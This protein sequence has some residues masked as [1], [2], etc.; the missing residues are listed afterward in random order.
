MMIAIS[1]AIGDPGN[2]DTWSGAPANLSKAL[3]QLGAD[4]GFIDS[5]C[6]FGYATKLV[7]AAAGY[8]AGKPLR[9]VSW[10]EP[11]R[12]RRGAFVEYRARAL[13]ADHVLCMGSL[14]APQYSSRPY[15]I[16]M[17]NTWDLLWNSPARPAG[18]TDRDYAEI[19]A[20]EREVLGC[21][22]HVFAFSHHVRA[23]L[24]RHYRIPEE[25]AL[26]VGCGSGPIRPF[27]G[28]KDYA[29]G[30]LLFVAKHLFA[31]KGGNLVL[32]A[33]ETIRRCRKQTKL[34]II[35]NDVLRDR[36]RGRTNV[37]VHGYL[38]WEELQSLYN[39][40]SMLVQPMLSDPWG[41]VYLEAMKT[42]TIVVS[43]NVAAVPEI[44]DGGRLGIMVDEP[45]PPALAEAVLEAFD[46]PQRLTD[47]AR[48]A[49][50]RVEERYTWR[51]V[52]Q[53]IYMRLNDG[54]A[55]SRALG[56]TADAGDL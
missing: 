43:L 25:R 8:L 37:T 29:K 20:A 46:H 39:G 40:S 12:R 33:F 51:A 48:E 14:D 10:R 13:Q 24:I 18:F 35:G 34:V 47:I 55:T 1:S 22:R 7:L 53:R 17:D 5:S 26:A 52:A 38:P 31:E 21:A 23:N 27:R 32:E 49:Q 2:P 6:A 11:A 4:M 16:Y 42:R 56:G 15:S 28:E 9:S 54:L 50:Q 41:Q 30:H 3:G 36:L 19:D 45:T 44:T